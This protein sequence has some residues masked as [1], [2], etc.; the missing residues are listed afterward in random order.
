[1]IEYIPYSV[2]VYSFVD[3]L[4]E[5]IFYDLYSFKVLP[6]NWKKGMKTYEVKFY[7]EQSMWDFKNRIV[8]FN[9]NCKDYIN[10]KRKCK[11]IRDAEKQLNRFIDISYDKVPVS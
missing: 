7:I 10:R 4:D 9:C 1:M 5:E 6:S 2:S 8:R 3:K 11:H